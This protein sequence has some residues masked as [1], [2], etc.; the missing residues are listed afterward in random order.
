MIIA[1]EHPIQEVPKGCPVS[2]KF[3]FPIY[4]WLW[5]DFEIFTFKFVTIC[6]RQTDLGN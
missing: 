5:D 2:S 1:C 4:V 3:S 6:F